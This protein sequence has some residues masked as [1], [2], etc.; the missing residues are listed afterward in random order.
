MRESFDITKEARRL[1][2][3]EGWCLRMVILKVL[4]HRLEALRSR[5]VH[6]HDLRGHHGMRHL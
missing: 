6:V 2:H 4:G 1:V 3:D 5:E